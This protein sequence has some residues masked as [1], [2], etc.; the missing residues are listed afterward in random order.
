MG[1]ESG[2]GGSNDFPT[3][4]STQCLLLETKLKQQCAR[5]IAEYKA[6]KRKFATIKIHYSNGNDEFNVRNDNDDPW[7]KEYKK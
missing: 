6:G 7:F 2:S 1:R 3:K 5:E 4:V